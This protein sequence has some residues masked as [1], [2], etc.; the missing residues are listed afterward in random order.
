MSKRSLRGIVS[1]AK[2]NETAIVKVA[3]KKQ[4]PIYLKRFIRHES[5]PAHNPENLYQVGDEVLIEETRPLS[6][7]KRWIIRER[8]SAATVVPAPEVIE[9]TVTQEESAT[10]KP[11]A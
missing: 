9:K 10:E 11:T 3:M 7:T 8:L 2:M 1:A 5:Y 4:H 6:K